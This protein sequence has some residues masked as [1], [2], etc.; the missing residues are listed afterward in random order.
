M[1]LALAGAYANAGRDQ[2]ARAEYDGAIAA[3]PEDAEAYYSKAL[4]LKKMHDEAGS[5][6]AM[7]KSCELGKSMACVMVN[8]SLPKKKPR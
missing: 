8:L 4:F 6:A 2:E 7:Q 1:R 5:L 3:R